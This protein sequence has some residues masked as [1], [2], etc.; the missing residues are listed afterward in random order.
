MQLH[1]MKPQ[2]EMRFLNTERGC[3]LL[4][5]LQNLSTKSIRECYVSLAYKPL[6]IFLP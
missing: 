5:G 2:I 1:E 4:S 3:S 6:K